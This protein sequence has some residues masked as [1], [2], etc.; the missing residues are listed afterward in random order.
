LDGNRILSRPLKKQINIHIYAY[1]YNAEKKKR[2]TA[3]YTVGIL[4]GVNSSSDRSMETGLFSNG[5][6]H[7]D[8]LR[9]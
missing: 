6:V 3:N 7:N 5:S 4:L 1:A 8:A 9:V 2:R